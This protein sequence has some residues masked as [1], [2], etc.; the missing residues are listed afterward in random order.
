MLWVLSESAEKVHERAHTWIISG[1][2]VQDYVLKLLQQSLQGCSN[3]HWSKYII[4][5]LSKSDYDYDHRVF[6]TQLQQDSSELIKHVFL[7]S[8]QGEV[9]GL[10]AQ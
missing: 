10:Q 2:F 8:V 4:F 5:I 3:H 7:S 1:A 6:Y 9:S